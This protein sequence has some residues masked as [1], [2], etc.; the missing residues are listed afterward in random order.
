MTLSVS[1]PGVFAQ[2]WAVDKEWCGS[3]HS[4][5]LT[6]M[7]PFQPKIFIEVTSSIT[8]IARVEKTVIS[9]DGEPRVAARF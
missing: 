3:I 6:A 2:Q 9:L 8:A 1:E 5:R 4:S 7:I